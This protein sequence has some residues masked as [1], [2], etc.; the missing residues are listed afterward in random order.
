MDARAWAQYLTPDVVM[1]FG[2]DDPLYGRGGSG[3][4]RGVIVGARVS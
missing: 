2:N 3:S 4:P 1:R